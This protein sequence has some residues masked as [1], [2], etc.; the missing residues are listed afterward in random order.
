MCAHTRV[1]TEILFLT[2]EAQVVYC[3]TFYGSA[4]RF[5]SGCVSDFYECHWVNRVVS[6]RTNT[7]VKENKLVILR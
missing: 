3:F 6:P 2:K 4:Y 5:L 7:L 1:L